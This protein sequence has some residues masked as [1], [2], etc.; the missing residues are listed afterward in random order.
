[1]PRVCPKNRKS[2][3]E[4]ISKI[5]I[6]EEKI[7]IKNHNKIEKIK[8]TLCKKTNLV[9]VDI[10][11]DEIIN[12]VYELFINN[13][14]DVK[15]MDNMYL[16]YLAAYYLFP[17]NEKDKELNIAY[18]HLSAQYGN[19]HASDNIGGYYTSG[20]NAST[21][22]AEKYL[23]KAIELDN[24]FE[25]PHEKLFRL[26]ERNNDN[27]KKV[28]ICLSA[29]KNNI[30]GFRF[31]L[32]FYYGKL[33]DFD[34][35]HKYYLDG[36][37]YEKCEA[38]MYNY[39][40]YFK[41]EKEFDNMKKYFEMVIEQKKDI[42]TTFEYAKYY[43]EINDIDNAIKYYSMYIDFEESFV[44]TNKDDNERLSAI[45]LFDV[46]SLY[47][48]IYERKISVN[49]IKPDVKKNYVKYTTKKRIMENKIKCLSK[50]DNCPLCMHDSTVIPLD[51]CLHFYCEDCYIKL[52]KCPECHISA[53]YDYNVDGII[54]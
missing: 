10:N 11:N 40:V 48:K 34:N 54:I 29:I 39:G 2:R 31:Y 30:G 51:C 49:K 52:N 9:Y 1:M 27:D 44:E 37:T 20:P 43:Q 15:E 33:G 22:L 35:M 7:K 12:K 36:I 17:E 42:K 18:T 23:Y 45:L 38:C 25:K 13:I 46:I 53:T 32:G 47:E 16:L 41:G 6:A 14:I 24:A 4:L 5:N 50:E 8:E 19:K 21:E 28:E 26:Y 3:H